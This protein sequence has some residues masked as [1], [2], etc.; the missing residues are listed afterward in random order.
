[1][2]HPLSHLLFHEGHEQVEHSQEGWFQVDMM[3]AFGTNR[4]AILE[5]GIYLHD[6]FRTPITTKAV[7]IY[8][9]YVNII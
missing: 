7:I 6:H 8:G 1:M 2:T 3:H 9:Q 5:Q 4:V